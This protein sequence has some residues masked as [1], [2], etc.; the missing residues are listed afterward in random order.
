MQVKQMAT[1]MSG[2]IACVSSDEEDQDPEED[3]KPPPPPK[4]SNEPLV[5]QRQRQRIA[6]ARSL[7]LSARFHR[8]VVLLRCFRAWRVQT[9]LTKQMLRD[10]WTIM[11]RTLLV[12]HDVSMRSIEQRQALSLLQ[13]IASRCQRRLLSSALS[14]WSSLAVSFGLAESYLLAWRDRTRAELVTSRANEG[15]ALNFNR[16]FLMKSAFIDWQHEALISTHVRHCNLSKLRNF[17]MAWRN[18]TMGGVEHRREALRT[19]AKQRSDRTTKRVFAMWRGDTNKTTEHRNALLI[20]ERTSQRSIQRQVLST[21][22]RTSKACARFDKASSKLSS[23]A[24]TFRIREAF[25]SWTGLTALIAHKEQLLLATIMNR[26]SMLVDERKHR[27]ALN[28]MALQFWAC[29]IC[30]RALRQ[31]KGTVGTIREEQKAIF[32]RSMHSTHTSYRLPPSLSP[33]PPLPSS[34]PS[35]STSI[36]TSGSGLMMPDRGGLRRTVL[37]S[38]DISSPL[39]TMQPTRSN[40]H[41]TRTAISGEKEERQRI[42]IPDSIRD[43]SSTTSDGS[44][45][46]VRIPK[47]IQEEKTSPR[48]QSSAAPRYR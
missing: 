31:W 16:H 18:R 1:Q 28:E 35:I 39:R 11:K 26:W 43:T 21:W 3:L 14:R 17:T 42:R 6:E 29:N 19:I 20:L 44:P 15:I 36:N 9:A 46:G 25:I 48:Y 33:L 41:P 23:V 2:S 24:D 32:R 13:S 37:T 34:S 22:L 10:A 30:K 5:F 38:T 12:W 45:F 40:Y 7:R 8:Q 4:I 27:R 47:W